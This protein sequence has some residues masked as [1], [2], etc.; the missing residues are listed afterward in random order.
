MRVATRRLRSCLELFR[1]LVPRTASS[2]VDAEI[3]WLTGELGPARDWDVFINE[4]LLAL[5]RHFP[6]HVALKA[7]TTAAERVRAR[8]YQTAQAAVRSSRYTRLLLGIGAWHT[9]RDWRDLIGPERCQNLEHPVEWFAANLLTQGHTRVQKWG[10]NFAQ[11]TPEE[12]HHLR[13][14]CKR[15]RYA[16]EFF[17][18]LYPDSGGRSYL[19]AVAG[20]QDVLGALND[21]TVTRRLLTEL[22]IPPED[23]AIHLVLGWKAAMTEQHLA[24]FDSA[25]SNFC[26]QPHFWK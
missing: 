15:L 3:R 17:I 12:R 2:G 9:R 11:L 25:W 26:D 16:G 20:L 4:T 14:L 7:L 13:I 10:Q 8:T 21:A 22:E 5:A 18:D 1:S 19:R 23:P 6:D 24:H